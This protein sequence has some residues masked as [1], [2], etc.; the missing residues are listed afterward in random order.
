MIKGRDPSCL[1]NRV[2]LHNVI[3]RNTVCI[4]DSLLSAYHCQWFTDKCFI[5]CVLLKATKIK[6]CNNKKI[7]F[8]DVTSGVFR[9]VIESLNKYPPT[10]A[11]YF[12]PTYHKSA[13]VPS[14]KPLEVR[15]STIKL[16]SQQ[17]LQAIVNNRYDICTKSYKRWVSAKVQKCGSHKDLVSVFS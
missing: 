15:S 16:Y 1:T 10:T 12:R 3:H 7:L 17:W 11:L 14:D 9:D 5:K 13:G 6:I 4:P 8:R 2:A